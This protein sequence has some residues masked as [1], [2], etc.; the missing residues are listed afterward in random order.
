MLAADSS[1]RRNIHALLYGALAFVLARVIEWI[2]PHYYYILFPL[3]IVAWLA[4]TTFVPGFVT[5]ILV[6]ARPVQHGA[7]LG[8]VIA[9]LNLLLEYAS[10]PRGPSPSILSFFLGLTIMFGFCLLGAW[11]GGKTARQHAP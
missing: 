10:H 7:W 5:G 1:E 9:P 2:L 8:G 11:L 4:L 6:N 3:A